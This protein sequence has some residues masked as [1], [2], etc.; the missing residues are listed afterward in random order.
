LTD[1]EVAYRIPDEVLI[2]HLS[3]G[4]VV[5]LDLASE[6][7]FGLDPV[8]AAMYTAL[9]EHGSLD[10]AIESLLA[11]YEVDVDTLR[12]DL[13]DLCE[14]LVERGLLAKVE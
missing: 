4:E 3:N 1:A 5:F 12:R 6:A 13:T 14:Q 7:Y 10:R 9:G 8:G 2:Q 11:E